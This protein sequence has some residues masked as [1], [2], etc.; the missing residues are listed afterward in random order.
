MFVYIL[1]CFILESGDSECFFILG[2]RMDQQ[3]M[4]A[5]AAS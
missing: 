3:K 2:Q 1:T 4:E 5:A